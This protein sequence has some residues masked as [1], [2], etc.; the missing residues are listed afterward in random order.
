[1]LSKGYLVSEKDFINDFKWFY[2]AAQGADSIGCATPQSE[3]QVLEL[4]KGSILALIGCLFIL[5]RAHLLWPM[6]R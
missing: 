1:M 2:R 3:G 6:L 4:Q 5:Y